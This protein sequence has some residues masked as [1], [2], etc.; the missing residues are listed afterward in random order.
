MAEDQAAGEAIGP[1]HQRRGSLRVRL[2]V[3]VVALVVVV[4]VVVSAAT[5]VTLRAFLVQQLDTQLIQTATSVVDRPFPELRGLPEGTLLLE[6]SPDG[7]LVQRPVLV[8]GQGHDNDSDS[9]LPTASDLQA[10]TNIDDHP[11][12]LRL[13]NLGSYRAV[14]VV[15]PS[16][17]KTI[18]AQSMRPIEQTLHRLLGIEAIA[19]TLASLLLAVASYVFIRRELAPLDRVAATARRV[20]RLPL[21]GRDAQRLDERVALKDAPTEVAEVAT[22]FNDMLEHVDSSLVARTASEDRLRHFVADAS[23]ELRTPLV[24]IRGYAE[25]YRRTD[26]DPERRAAAMD[27]IESEATRMGVLVDDL[28][29]LARLDQ[30]RP[31]LA[32]PVDLSLL[33]AEATADASVRTPDHRLV[34]DVPTEPVEVIGD[35]DRLRQVLANLLANATRHT[36]PGTTVTVAV[37]ADPAARLARLSVTDDGPGI[38]ESLQPRVFERFTR[39]DESRTRAA[40]GSGLGLSIVSAV[41]TALGGTVDLQS[42]PGRTCIEVRLPWQAPPVDTGATVQEAQR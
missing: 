29:L 42:R 3:G 17:N 20:S 30:G 11:E 23:H 32:E 6:V 22:A 31:L 35:A 19:V 9:D 15:D 7:R 12:S 10:L 34:L 37:G 38:P 5:Y 1:D 27:R 36:P 21:S 14:A 24:S 2:T 8:V 26:A 40:G 16:G 28:L 13:S 39:A 25:L 4:L 33:A 41:V 18:I